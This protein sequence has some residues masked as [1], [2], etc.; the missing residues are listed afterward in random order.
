[1]L[2]SFFHNPFVV[3]SISMLKRTVSSNTWNKFPKSSHLSL[4]T[5]YPPSFFNL[6]SLSRR[7]IAQLSFT[8][9]VYILSF[10]SIK[11]VLSKQRI[12]NLIAFFP[13]IMVILHK[14]SYESLT[15]ISI[16]RNKRSCIENKN[17]G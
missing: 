1:M 9:T 2:F 4:Q 10:H 14:L 13:A 17:N 15:L 8:S 16:I 11:F 5:A 12:L 7:V 3:I 6:S